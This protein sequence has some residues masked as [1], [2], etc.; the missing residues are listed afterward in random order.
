MPALQLRAILDIIPTASAA[1]SPPNAPA[2]CFRI[3]I[4]AGA[5]AGYDFG[6]MGQGFMDSANRLKAALML[7]AAVL[8]ATLPAALSAQEARPGRSIRAL[9]RPGYE[10][11]RWR[12]GAATLLPSLSASV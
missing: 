4:F 1:M 5:A 8:P 2:S 7:A 12:I 6:V 10:I 3:G 11:G 9:P